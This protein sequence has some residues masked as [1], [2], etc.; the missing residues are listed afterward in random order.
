ETVAAFQPEPLTGWRQIRDGELGL[1]PAGTGQWRNAGR[2]G[3]GI[4]EGIHDPVRVAKTGVDVFAFEGKGPS[5]PEAV[6]AERG[7]PLLDVK[8]VRRGASDV[9]RNAD[10]GG[11]TTA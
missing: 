10:V 11:H 3:H 6:D 8:E 7:D 2:A 5:L 1:C 9:S 4:D